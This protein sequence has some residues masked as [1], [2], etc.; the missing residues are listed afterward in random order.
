MNLHP[1]FQKLAHQLGMYVI[2]CMTQHSFTTTH[3]QAIATPS[4]AP[5]K[6]LGEPPDARRLGW[7][8]S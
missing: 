3:T 7:P 2:D 6:C 4:I 5:I 8:G 1:I